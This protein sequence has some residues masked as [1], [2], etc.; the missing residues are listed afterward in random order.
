MG[1]SQETSLESNGIPLSQGLCRAQG[2]DEFNSQG[3]QVLRT[4]KRKSVTD[5]IQ[6]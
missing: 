4:I 6:T 5:L 3:C 2:T 1:L